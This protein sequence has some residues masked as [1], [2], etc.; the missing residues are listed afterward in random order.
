MD[1]RSDRALVRACINGDADA[2][3]ALMERYGRQVHAIAYGVLLSRE[4]AEDVMQEAFTRAYQRLNTLRQPDRFAAWVSRVGLSCAHDVARRRGR[5]VVVDTRK[6][7]ADRPDRRIDQHAAGRDDDV[8][9]ILTNAL[10]ALPES[11]RLPVAMRFMDGMSHRDIAE[12]LA[13][14]PRAAETRIARGLR[15]MREHLARTGR[16]E[17]GRDLLRTYGL[18][19]GLTPEGL[20]SALEAIR[21]LLPH[22]PDTGNRTG[23][24]PFA[25]AGGVAMFSITLGLYGTGRVVWGD[26]WSVGVP[27]EGYELVAVDVVPAPLPD[28]YRPLADGSIVLYE[29]RF[30]DLRDG[31]A[32]RGWSAGVS[33][34]TTDSAAGGAGAAKVTTNIPAAWISFPRARGVVTIEASL[35]PALGSN[36]NLGLFVGNDVGG[37]SDSEGPGVQFMAFTKTS[38]DE[39]LYRRRDGASTMV[40]R[41]ADADDRWR[42]VRLTID[43]TRNVYDLQ[44]DGKTVGRDVPT[45]ADLAA[46]ISAVGINSGR[47][48]YA[49]DTASYFDELR[50]HAVVAGGTAQIDPRRSHDPP[51][52]EPTPGSYD[53]GHAQSPS[54]VYRDGVYH[55]WY[56]AQPVRYAGPQPGRTATAV[57]YAT[58]GDGRTWEKHGV[59]IEPT[60]GWEA[61]RVSAPA[62]L[63]HRDRFHMWYRG[64]SGAAGA[65]AIGHATS[66]DG[67]RWERDRM[68]PITVDG[69]IAAT[70]AHGPGSVV[71]AG[72]TYVM[73]AARGA[74][75]ARLTSIDGASW[76]DRGDALALDG[77]A[78]DTGDA[79]D[80]CVI[81]RDGTYEMWR[82]ADG[83]RRAT[84]IDGF[85][86][87]PSATVVEPGPPGDWSYPAIRHVWALADGAGVRLWYAAGAARIAIGETR[88]RGEVPAM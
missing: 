66:R 28:G 81:V 5:E 32:P 51:V 46:G 45:G 55:M 53:G 87:T 50:V 18:A 30:D 27:D 59:V 80:P 37:W 19:F 65:V 58:S 2:F 7:F 6:A 72:D 15:R 60:G 84:S 36:T 63:A 57:A 82:V 10:A 9:R 67:L 3:C 21:T 43:T 38:N 23:V 52:V 20:R 69:G 56:T 62:V 61:R 44:F 74:R 40:V 8:Q 75:V 22:T 35:R 33:A 24:L 49:E 11:M 79:S 86:W 39:W 29:Q 47:W 54:V 31:A 4:D 76:H 64:E 42:R 88:W 73:W 14:T 78:W 17:D 1:D 77:A 12:A 68:N 70:L 85:H 25:L 13:I 48:G 26:A 83:L 34:A 16:E 41:V 71:A